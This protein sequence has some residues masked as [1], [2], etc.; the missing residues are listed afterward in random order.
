ML[1]LI[2]EKETLD[3]QNIFIECYMVYICF[4]LSTSR[5]CLFDKQSV[6]AIAFESDWTVWRQSNWDYSIYGIKL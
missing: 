3:L 2:G 5:C 1:K 6:N 4:S